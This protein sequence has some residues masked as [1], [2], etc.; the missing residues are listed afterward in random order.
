MMEVTGPRVS[1]GSVK[2]GVTG[3]PSLCVVSTHRTW[4]MVEMRRVV[5]VRKE[6][7][8]SVRLRKA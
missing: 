6:L 7:K 3:E 8:A 5:S 4:W 1:R 2:R